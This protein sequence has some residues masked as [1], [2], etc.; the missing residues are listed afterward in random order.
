MVRQPLEQIKKRTQVNRALDNY[1]TNLEKSRE[2][3][4]SAARAFFLA[5]ILITLGAAGFESCKEETK[6]NVN[7]QNQNENPEPK[8]NNR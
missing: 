3:R 1:L 5:S 8:A 6:T 7:P 2:K 4:V